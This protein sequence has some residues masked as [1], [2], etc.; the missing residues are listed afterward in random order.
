MNVQYS[1][2][3]AN[4]L[5]RLD[6]STKK[7]IREA[8]ASLPDG[9]IKQLTGRTSVYRLRVGDW[10]VLFS[11]PNGDTVLVEKIAPRGQVYREG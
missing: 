11:Y 4:I 1:K 5:D 9:D 6:A 3:A 2:K 8:I 10:R 7:R